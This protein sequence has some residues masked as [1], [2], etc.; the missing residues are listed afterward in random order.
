MINFKRNSNGKK[1][2]N[3]RKT[4]VKERKTKVKLI[5]IS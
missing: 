3:K 4:K 5:H 1:E 2:W